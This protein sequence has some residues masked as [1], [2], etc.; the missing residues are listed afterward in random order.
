MT[1]LTCPKCRH[2]VTD[3]ALDRGACPACGFPFDGPV[4]LGAGARGAPRVLLA[5]TLM[6]A[7]GGAGAA[8]YFVSARAPAEPTREVTEEKKTPTP[9]REVFVAPFPHEPRRAANPDPKKVDPVPPVP[10]VEPPK[11][12]GPR[13]VAAKVIVN[14]KVEPKRH[15]DQPDDIVQV[16]DVHSADRVVLTGRVRELR[17]SQVHGKGSVDAS[18]LIAE[19]VTI[20][21]DLNSEA[22]VTLNAPNGKVSLRG[23]IGGNTKL[24]ILAP[25][26][27]VRLENSGRC[28]G[29]STVTI[30]AKRFEAL[31]P[32][33][34]GTKVNLTLTAG[35]SL[36]FVRAEEGATV[37]YR[38]TGANEPPLVVDRGQLL[39]GARVQEGK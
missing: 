5:V 14:P 39:G 24:T 21:A 11:K 13:P 12:D 15:F 26:G 27:E 8:G 16:L 25:N 10:P 19:E 4:V 2:G 28:T 20:T 17:L 30:T 35:G 6:A 38:K 32:L 33:S 37:T 29:G 31:G 3:D 23:F 34:G 9:P 18:G 36:K 22:T 7:A 1:S